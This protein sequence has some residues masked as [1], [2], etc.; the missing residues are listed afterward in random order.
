M[1][2]EHESMVG[3]SSWGSIPGY[4]HVARMNGGGLPFVDVPG[5][6][7]PKD[8]SRDEMLLRKLADAGVPLRKG[9]KLDYDQ[10]KAL[11]ENVR[12][13]FDDTDPLMNTERWMASFVED[14]GMTYTDH[15]GHSYVMKGG[16]RKLASS[17][18]NDEDEPAD[19]DEAGDEDEDEEVRIV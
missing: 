17:F 11:Y 4:E 1:V 14:R 19:E 7:L 15:D 5:T 3:V 10:S 9:A 6:R 16:V 18:D 8:G 2:D 12:S 13:Y